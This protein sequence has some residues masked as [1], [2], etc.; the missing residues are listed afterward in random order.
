MLEIIVGEGTCGRAA[1]SQVVMAEIKKLLPEAKILSVGC[2]GMC[3]REVIV[4]VNDKK[5]GQKYIYGDINGKNIADV[6]NFHKGE[7]SLPTDLLIKSSKEPRTEKSKYLDK[8]VR[9]ALR[10]VGEIDPTSID[11][12]IK[13]G[14]YKSIEHV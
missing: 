9:I 2:V 6:V 13:R 7:G 3:H 10:N 4:E 12:Y 5:T 1:G 14:G 11:D 8:Q